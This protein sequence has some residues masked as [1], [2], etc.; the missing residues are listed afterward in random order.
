MIDTNILTGA[1]LN[2]AGHN[3]AVIRACLERKWRPLIGQALFL[4]YEDVLGRRHL[5]RSCPL[6][7]GERQEFF[8]AFLSV[9]EWVEIY[10][11]WRPNLPDEGENHIVELAVAGGAEVIVTNNGRDFRRAQLRFPGLRTV[12]P[13]EFLKE[14]A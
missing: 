5:F 12:S 7:Q 3:R 9:C 10:F 4:E 13:H 2:R 6:S 14:L 11:S 8:A 1:L